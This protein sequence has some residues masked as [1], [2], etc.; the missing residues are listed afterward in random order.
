MVAVAGA[1]VFSFDLD[2]GAA[3]FLILFVTLW[4]LERDE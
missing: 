3:I 1:S 4:I 2:L